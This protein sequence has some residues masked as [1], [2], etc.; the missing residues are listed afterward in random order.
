MAVPCPVWWVR[1][2]LESRNGPA[3]RAGTSARQEPR[4]NRSISL[5][6]LCSLGLA[7][8]VAMALGS[9]PRSLAHERDGDDLRD[10]RP[11]PGRLFSGRGAGG[12]IPDG[13]GTNMSGAPLR[14]TIARIF[15]KPTLPSL[16]MPNSPASKWM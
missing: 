8:L 3:R 1:H 13:I 5:R 11:A 7:V 15:A 2:V 10:A 4:M 12:V 9:P 6:S 14:S 16:R